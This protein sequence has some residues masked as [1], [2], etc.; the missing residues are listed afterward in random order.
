MTHTS[1]KENKGQYQLKGNKVKKTM[2]L[3][4]RVD[5]MSVYEYE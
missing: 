4:A 3:I 2:L 5:C 1:I